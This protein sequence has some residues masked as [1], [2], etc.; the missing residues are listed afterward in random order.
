MFPILN[1]GP[2]AIQLPGLILL[3]GY[4]LSLNLAARRAKA[5]GLSEDVVF[6]G[7]FI[8]LLLG[9][10]GA[11]LGYVAL[12]WSAY[13]NDLSGVL[14]L[15]AGALSMP[16][17]VLIGTGV[18]AFYLRRHRPSLPGLLD[19]LAPAL[20]LL[21]ASISLAD[22]SGGSGY[23]AVSDVPWGIDLWGARRHP[24]QV[25]ELL[26]AL[27]T[28]GL[29]WWARARAP[30]DGFLFLLFLLSYGGARLF[31]DAFRAAPWLLP[32]GYRA[33]QVVGLGAVV[34][35]LWLIGRRAIQ[36]SGGADWLPHA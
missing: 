1:I 11:R 4:W 9:L 25:Y 22:L 18:A 6:N 34:A 12:N 24:T 27:A 10:I 3:L 30:H 7:G 17:G 23:G 33:V 19:A 15:T 26:A 8:A 14:A 32:G 35:S 20:A 13:Q 5:A 21:F 29:L 36:A 2:A 16:A 28:L 31:L